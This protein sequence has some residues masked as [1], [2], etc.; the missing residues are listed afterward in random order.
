[1]KKQLTVLGISVLLM[2]GTS[3]MASAQKKEGKNN[4]K[5]Q[6]HNQG[7]NDNKGAK[8]SQTSLIYR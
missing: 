1:M 2:T 8:T 6:E 5:E 7:K 4:K 3:F